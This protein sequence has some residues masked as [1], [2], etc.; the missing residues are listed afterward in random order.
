M[1]SSKTSSRSPLRLF[2][3]SGGRN[4]DQ[5][6]KRYLRIGLSISLSSSLRSPSLVLGFELAPDAQGQRLE[7]RLRRVTGFDA[8]RSAIWRSGQRDASTKLRFRARRSFECNTCE[9]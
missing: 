6:T 7:R 5:V 3:W 2:L 1:S 4:K 9:E 8:R